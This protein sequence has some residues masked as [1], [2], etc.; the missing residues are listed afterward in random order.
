MKKVLIVDDNDRYANNLK[1]Y[2]DGKKIN[3]DR[4]VDAKQGLELFTKSNDYD[5]IISDVTMET[6]TSGLWMMRKIYKSGYKGVLVIASTGFD[7]WGVMPF[8]SYFLSWFCGLHWMIPKVPLKQGTV[9]W[10]PTVLSKDKTN[11]F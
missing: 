5:M 9:E 4:A 10:V 11:P 8:S 6:Q 3:S 7:V 2:L 1:L